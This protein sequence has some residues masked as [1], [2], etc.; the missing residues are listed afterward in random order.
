[1][2]GNLSSI[3]HEKISPDNVSSGDILEYLDGRRKRYFGVLEVDL[4]RSGD[5]LRIKEFCSSNSVEEPGR[6]LSR[7]PYG[8]PFVYNLNSAIR[9]FTKV[10]YNADRIAKAHLCKI[11]A[12]TLFA[13]DELRNLLIELEI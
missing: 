10:S 13:T 11:V 9:D 8:N 5:E 7:S 4:T 1:M 3:K 6:H 2:I 12:A